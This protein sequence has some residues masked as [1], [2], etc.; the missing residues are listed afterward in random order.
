MPKQKIA[1]FLVMTLFL[2]A[3]TTLLENK[4]QQTITIG[5][6]LPLTGTNAAYGQLARVGIELAVQD[7]N[8]QERV[9][10]NVI[11]E[12]AGT[13]PMKAATAAQKLIEIDNVKG[14]VTFL[15]PLGGAIAPIAEEKK[16]PFIYLAA[17]NKFVQ[18]KTFVFKD[19]PAAEDLCEVLMRQ[20]TQ[21][22]QNIAL[23]GVNAEFTQLCKQGTE[24]VKPLTAFETY[25]VGSVEFKTQLTKIKSSGATALITAVWENE[26]Q[27]L[28]RQ[29]NELGLQQQLYIFFQSFGCGTANM[30]LN[31]Q[32][33][34]QDAYGTDIAVDNTDSFNIFTKRAQQAGSPHIIGTAMFYDNTKTLINAIKGCT[35]STCVA[36]KLRTSIT[37]GPSGTLTFNGKQTSE[38]TIGLFKLENNTWMRTT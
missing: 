24:K 1:I 21:T 37:T 11:F 10:A 25:D 22:H 19:Y 28:F 3:C 9:P 23:F 2:S 15:T 36:D 30:I 35:D 7:A 6:I 26:C 17:T 33:I 29:M 4:E 20:A 38:R 13:D 5:A 16:I 14:L 18:N 31:N 12:D 32:D 8:Q 27:T 34:L